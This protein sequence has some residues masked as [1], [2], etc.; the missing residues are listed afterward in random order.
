MVME[1]GLRMHAESKATADFWRYGHHRFNNF[2]QTVIVL[3]PNF[4]FLILKWTR[5][6]LAF[7]AELGFRF[8]LLID[9]NDRVVDI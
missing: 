3:I 2:F 1:F 4:A 5:Y 6:I 9:F 8:F 7:L